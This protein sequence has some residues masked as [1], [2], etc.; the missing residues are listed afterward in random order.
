MHVDGF[1]FDL[2]SALAREAGKVENL[3]GFF[4][5]IRQDPT[6]NRVKLIAE[7][8]DLG[9]GGYQ[10]GNFPPGWAEWND[11]Y[12]DGVRSWWKG[13]AGVAGEAAHRLTSSQD[14]YG[15]SG[16]GPHASINFVTAHDGFTL[17]DLVS[18]NEKHNEANG[19]DNRDGHNNN[20]SWNCGAEGPTDDPAVR[21][22]RERQKR[23]LLATLLLSQGVPMLLAGDERGHT[24]LGNNNA[25][26]QDN[27]LTWL[28]WTPS[29]EADL[30][31]DFVALL[32]H[33]RRRH[34]SFR[35]RSFFRGQPSGDG[36]PKDVEWLRPDGQEMAPEDWGDHVRCLGML[37]SGTGIVDMGP[38]GE[39]QRDDDFLLLLNA[40]HEPLAFALPSR[41]G[42]SWTR[43]IDTAGED[44]HPARADAPAYSVQGRSLVLLRRSLLT[45]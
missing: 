34:P 6:L 17:H 28:D 14:L 27:E 13:D 32:T 11:R 10:V 15:W 43:M 36:T 44:L 1:R 4:D 2:A 35:R 23:N 20:L 18:Y 16:K 3:G 9:H 40:Y 45:S 5:A 38:R 8:W 41:P 21:A 24:Q 33:T 22:L 42:E 29:P 39:T 30:L 26:C 37:F 25:Y 19:E 12:R 7:P 31:H